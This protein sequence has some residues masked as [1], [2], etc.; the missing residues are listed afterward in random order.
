M[1]LF[2]QFTFSKASAAK[3]PGIQATDESQMAA[4]PGR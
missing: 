2:T 1:I 3:F 4:T